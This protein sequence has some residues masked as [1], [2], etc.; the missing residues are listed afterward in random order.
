MT[1]GKHRSLI[2]AAS[3]L[4]GTNILMRVVIIIS[5]CAAQ[6]GCATRPTPQVATLPDSPSNS[7]S[8]EVL[9]GEVACYKQNIAKLSNGPDAASDVAEAVMGVCWRERDRVLGEGVLAVARLA[10]VNLALVR[11]QLQTNFDRD[12][13]RTLMSWIV[14]ARAKGMRP[15]PAV[16]AP[17]VT[18]PG[19]KI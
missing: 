13:R 4:A 10:P 17:T 19:T 12:D 18:R 11:D 8:D 1:V 5:I 6:A 15:P 16:Q 9:K 7:N 3:A 14:E 2:S